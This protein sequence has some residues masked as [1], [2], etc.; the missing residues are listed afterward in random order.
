MRLEFGEFVVDLD[1]HELQ[2]LGERVRLEPKVFDVLHHL[3]VNRD[4]VVSKDELLR[5]LWSGEHVIDGVVT[6]CVYA[7]RKVLDQKDADGPP[8]AT[9]RGRGYRFTAEARA[10]D[11]GVTATTTTR[12]PFVGRADELARLRDA[13]RAARAG[14]GRIVWLS[15]D[16]G[17]GKTRL[18]DEI[19]AIARSEGIAVWVARCHAQEG[20]PPLWLWTQVIRACMEERPEAEVRRAL[21][22]GFEELAA[23]V[24]ERTASAAVTGLRPDREAAPYRLFDA[25][26]GVLRL[27]TARTPHLLVLDDVHWADVPSLQLLGFVAPEIAGW[28]LCV[29]AT[30]RDD[31]WLGDDPKRGSLAQIARQR[32]FERVVLGPLRVEAVHEYVSRVFG[33]PSE[34]IAEALHRTSEGNAFFMVETLRAGSDDPNVAVDPLALP[35]AVKDVVAQRL[36]RLSAEARAALE[37]SAVVGRTFDVRVVAHALALDVRSTLA[38]LEPAVAARLVVRVTEHQ[39]RFSFGHGLVRETLYADVPAARRAMWHARAAEALEQAEPQPLG[40]IAQHYFRALPDGDPAKA[41]EYARRA[42]DAAAVVHSHDTAARCYADALTAIEQAPQIASHTTRHALLVAFGHACRMAGRVTNAADAFTRAAD[43]ARRSGRAVDLAHAAIGLRDCHSSRAVPDPIVLDL[44]DEALRALPDENVA[45]RAQILSRL[46]AV[47]S[48]EVRRSLSE[49]AADLA[50]RSGDAAAQADVLR[51]RL[52]ALQGPGEIAQRL[53]LA[54]ELVALAERERQPAWAWEALVARYDAR[55]R[56]GEMREADAALDKCAELA[57]RLRHPLLR[58]EVDRHRAQRALCSGRYAEAERG[59]SETARMATRLQTPF[60]PFYFMVQMMWLLR[61]RGL[62][63]AVEG[64]GERFV[65]RHPWAEATS[66]AAVGVFHHERGEP[67]AA[68]ACLMFYARE[69]FENVLHGEDYVA[70]SAQLAE[71]CAAL[72]EREH[73]A[74]VHAMLE[75]YADQNVVNGPLLYLGSAAHFL[76]L[77]DA[78]LGRDADARARFETALATNERWGAMPALVRTQEAYANLLQRVGDTV[79]AHAAAEA[80]RALRAQLTAGT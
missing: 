57:E 3:V 77:L 72:G 33:G 75:P 34:A 7:L 14:R 2:R 1:R 50:A 29:V 61:D 64:E 55:L 16:A 70:V 63:H 52:H 41:A 38:A 32:A 79:G 17:I 42:G 10:A 8:L 18:A 46:A 31:E 26:V 11:A 24:P 60:G 71:L 51:A 76:G 74:T 73:A 36:T 53:R 22:A 19:A 13:L 48:V 62:L 23:I 44:L 54:D 9:I 43:L 47:R 27:T 78:V 69:R 66:R 58:M 49:R 21:G 56:R 40:E 68:R 65:A 30:A 45:L 37:A 20:A 12:E 15:G 25:V 4:R 67:A 5:T 59:I 35:A 6:R 80:A 39:G 28:S